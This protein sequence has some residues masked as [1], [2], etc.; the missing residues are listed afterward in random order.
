MVILGKSP[1][2]LQK[3]LDRFNLYCHEW[4]LTVNV[5]KT[6]IVVF[7]KSG[8]L[9]ENERWHF[10]NSYIQVV[11]DFNYL[12][13]VFNYST[14]TFI[15]NNEFITGKGLKALHTLITNTSKYDF[16]VKILLQLFDTFVGSTLNYVCEITGFSK[17]KQIERIHLK[18]LRYILNVKQSTSTIS[19]YGELRRYPLYI[20]RNVRIIKYWCK[21]LKSENILLQQIYQAML[22]DCNNGLKNWASNVKSLLDTTGFS[23]IWYTQSSANLKPFPLIFKIIDMFIQN[24]SSCINNNQSTRIYKDIKETFCI[25]DYITLLPKHLYRF[26]AKI[27]LS[28]HIL[29]LSQTKILD[30]SKFK[31]LADDNF[32]FDENGRKFSKRVENTVGKRE[33]A[34][35]EQFLLFPQCFQKTCTADT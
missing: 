23:D 11:N 33:I 24:W 19:L 3:S 34:R 2:D 4:G 1:E 14:G 7:R 21:L 5:E 26:I 10:N 27:R 31:E 12:G 25:E 18:F 17:S 9:R 20:S 28:S 22:I 35:Y 8:L 15:L 29:T 6:K 16:K 13:T 32:K 30:Y